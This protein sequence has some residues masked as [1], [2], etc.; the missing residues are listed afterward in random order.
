MIC[1]AH[2]LFVGAI[3]SNSDNA[4]AERQSTQET[5]DKTKKSKSMQDKH[6]QTEDF[7]GTKTETVEAKDSKSKKKTSTSYNNSFYFLCRRE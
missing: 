1:I 3:R 7:Q 2:T 5:P 4:V 6:T